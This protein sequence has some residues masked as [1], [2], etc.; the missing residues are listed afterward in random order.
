[1][2]RGR[3]VR[4][5]HPTATVSAVHVPSGRYLVVVGEARAKG[6][7]GRGALSRY[8]T[9]QDAVRDALRQIEAYPGPWKVE[10]I[11]TPGTI[12]RDVHRPA[13][14]NLE[15]RILTDIGRPDLA[16]PARSRKKAKRT[17]RP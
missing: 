15:R 3:R 12:Y 14:H 7:G 9:V 13:V 17:G 5:W 2:A 8:G 4:V 6:T 11:S 16:P 10:A 1:M